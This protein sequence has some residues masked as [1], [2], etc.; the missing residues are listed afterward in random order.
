MKLLERSSGKIGGFL[1]TAALMLLFWIFLSG[2]LDVEHLLIGAASAVV[3]SLS[4]SD[5]LIGEGQKLPS[6]LALP[7]FLLYLAHLL[8]EI[9]KANLQVARLVLDPRLPISPSIVKFK[10]S[11]RTRTARASL[12]NSIT[13]TPGTLTIDVVGDQFYVHA[14]TRR[15]AESVKR[16]YME[17]RLKEVED[18]F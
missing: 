13:L 17:K 8:I 18:A 14:L 12:A 6:P 4:S 10:T 9:V 1:A 5:L 2:E 15:S 11:L 3:V 16:W 7:F